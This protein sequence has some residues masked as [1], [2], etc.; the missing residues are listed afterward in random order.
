MGAFGGQRLLTLTQFNDIELF[1]DSVSLSW[2]GGLYY[3]VAHGKTSVTIRA[4]RPDEMT[5][6]SCH[7]PDTER[8][9]LDESGIRPALICLFPQVE[10]YIGC[11]SLARQKPRRSVFERQQHGV[12]N[13]VVVGVSVSDGSGW[14]CSIDA[15]TSSQTSMA[16]LSCERGSRSVHGFGMWRPLPLST[17][18]NNLILTETVVCVWVCVCVVREREREREREISLYYRH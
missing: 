2:S 14:S 11:L 1:L 3:C 10:G 17:W 18:N 4:H 7:A 5:L 9:T 6:K 15:P 13:F 16:I 12:G 8:L